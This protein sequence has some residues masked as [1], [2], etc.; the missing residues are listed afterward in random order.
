MRHTLP[1]TY[2]A[3]VQHIQSSPKFCRDGQ[4]WQPADFPGYTVVTPP[5]KA[6]GKNSE[7]YVG[8]T[9]FQE[10][11]AQ[12]LGAE[13]FIPIPATSFHLTLADVIWADAYEHARKTSGFDAKLQERVA[14]S[15][16][17]CDPFLVGEPIRFQVVG[18]MVMTRAISM[19][20]AATDEVGYYNI[21]NLRRALYQNPGL[22]EIGIEQQYYFT[23]HITLGYF[24]D[25]STVD[26]EQLSHQLDQLNQTWIATSQQEFWVHQAEL[27]RFSNMT[28]YEREADWPTLKF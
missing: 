6:D 7:L 14:Q 8:L 11:V 1:E 4:A 19:A 22:I 16:L 2:K 20:L 24:G 27:R 3:Q 12:T 23:P 9:Q 13:C 26:R 18:L 17:Q 5:G 25:L 28:A 10:Q 21:L 15:F